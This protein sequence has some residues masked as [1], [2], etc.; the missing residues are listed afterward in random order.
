MPD[1]EMAITEPPFKGMKLMPYG[2]PLMLDAWIGCVMWA[3]GQELIVAEF[4]KETGFN[5]NFFIHR[6]ALDAAIDKATGFEREIMVRF[7]DF[8]T[9]RLWGIEGEGPVEDKP[10]TEIDTGTAS[11]EA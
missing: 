2:L 7:C 6:S 11:G 3:S 10:C 1:N 8:V 4:C 5:A 9:E